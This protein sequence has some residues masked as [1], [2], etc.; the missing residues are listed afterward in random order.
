MIFNNILCVN[1]I[2][3]ALIIV[4]ALNFYFTNF[5]DSIG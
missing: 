3:T 5:K 1:G 4:V 2:C